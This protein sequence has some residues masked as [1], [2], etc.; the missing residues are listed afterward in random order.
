MSGE[1]KSPGTYVR[2]APGKNQDTYG[3]GVGED[4]GVESL[5]YGDD[6]GAS[7]FFPQFQDRQELL[8]WLKTLVP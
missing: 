4:A 1:T 5:N 7:R 3:K 8:A 6:G 2:T